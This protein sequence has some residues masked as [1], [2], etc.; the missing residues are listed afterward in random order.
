M[1]QPDSKRSHHNWHF[2]DIVPTRKHSQHALPSR[3]ACIRQ[4]AMPVRLHCPV[5]ERQESHTCLLWPMQ[6]DSPYST[7]FPATRHLRVSGARSALASRKHI[8]VLC[9]LWIAQRIK[10][11]MTQ[12][13]QQPTLRGSA[14]DA[15]MY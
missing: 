5:I 1:P 7:M 13:F 15:S 3:P 6:E 8:Y 12:R 2:M 9:E 11:T 4:V 14:S 10:R